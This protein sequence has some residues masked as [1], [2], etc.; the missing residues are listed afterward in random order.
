MDKVFIEG[1]EL[2]CRVGHIAAERRLPQSLRVD[3]ELY[4]SNLHISGHSDRLEDTI[5]YSISRNL[6]AAVQEREFNLIET[7]AETLAQT[8][9]SFEGV[10]GIK[11]TLRKRAPIESVHFV[12]VEIERFRKSP[13]DPKT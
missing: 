3:I 1:L 13:E 11:V 12:G 10:E 7:V 2:P 8:A 6:I 5:D 9:L 4:Y